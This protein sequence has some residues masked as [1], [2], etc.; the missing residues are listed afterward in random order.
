MLLLEGVHIED[1]GKRGELSEIVK[2]AG[3][4]GLRGMRQ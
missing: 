4:G 3:Q 1:T 2:S